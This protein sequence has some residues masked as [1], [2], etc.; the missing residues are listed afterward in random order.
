MKSIFRSLARGLARI[1]VLAGVGAALITSSYLVPLLLGPTLAPLAYGFGLCLV[2][3]AAGD[4][5]LRVLQPGV[6]AQSA[7]DRAQSASSDHGVNVG[8][9]LVYLGRSILAAVVLMLIV[10][11]PRAAEPPAAAVPLLPL[12]KAEQRMWWP[13]HPMP[14]ALGAQIE[15]E[16]CYSLKHP[17]CWSPRA[18]LRTARERGVGLGQITRT[19]RFNALAELRGQFPVALSGWSWDAPSLYDPAIQMRAMILMDL[20]NWRALAD[21][22]R[23]PDRMAMALAAY[24]GGQGGLSSDRRA[25]AGTP[26]CDPARW[27]GHVELTSLKAKTA[28]PGYGKSFFAINREYP[29]NILIVRRQRYLVLET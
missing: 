11:A 13:D 15:Q 5:A 6:D 21:V 25:C 12:L 23:T 10:T 4:A 24:N 2:G 20:R 29:V 27:W 19:S 26:G 18:E 16:T 8:A 7:A 28:V 9:G 3:L 14:S 17:R 1:A 22:G